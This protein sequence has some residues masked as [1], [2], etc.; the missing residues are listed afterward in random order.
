MKQI[1]TLSLALISCQLQAHQL[2]YRH[3]KA[4]G[5]FGSHITALIAAVIHTNGPVLELGCG[6][7]STPQ[8]HAICAQHQRKLVSTDTSLEW[9]TKFSKVLSTDWHEFI[10][11]PVYENDWDI[12]PKPYLW[13]EIGTDT[14]WSVVL[15][16]HRPGERRKDDLLRF[17]DQAEIIVV[18]DTEVNGRCGYTNVQSE[19]G[20]EPIFEQF[21][22]RV[23][24]DR[25]NPLTT[26]V[27]N[28]IDVSKIFAE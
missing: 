2:H 12:N 25:F 24:F 15:I 4:P 28:S 7:G 26:I 11:V 6:W 14:H 5:E 17:K 19:Y 8:L 16:D 22:Y 1:L 18:H 3:K 9:L 23:D 10:Y 20:L 27:S 13:D 21:K